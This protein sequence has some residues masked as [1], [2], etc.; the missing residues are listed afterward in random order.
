ME[1]WK[2]CP[3]FEDAYEVSSIGR[4]RSLERTCLQTRG[5]SGVRRVPA[6]IIREFDRKGYRAVTLFKNG[7]PHPRSVHRLV[8]EAWHGPPPSESH[9]VAHRDGKPLNCRYKNLRW[10]TVKENHLD[11]RRHGTAW[12]GN[13]SLTDEQVIEVRDSAE[14]WRYFQKKYGICKSTVYN[15]RSKKYYG[16]LR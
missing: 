11:K 15:I 4:V 7:K 16:H 3:G 2:P 14:S 8:C 9:Q 12:E 1:T 13:R 5:N 10:A 6:K